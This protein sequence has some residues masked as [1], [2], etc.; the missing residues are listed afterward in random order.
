MSTTPTQGIDDEGDPRRDAVMFDFLADARESLDGTLQE[1]HAATQ[2]LHRRD[3]ERVRAD[4][5]TAEGV[6]DRIVGVETQVLIDGEPATVTDALRRQPGEAPSTATARG[7]A[8]VQEHT[9]PVQHHDLHQVNP[10]DPQDPSYTEG[11]HQ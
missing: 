4:A 1:T 8:A 11:L 5:R 6:D 10:D 2:R 9:E 7:I 3:M